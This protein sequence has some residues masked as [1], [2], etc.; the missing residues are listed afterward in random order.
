MQ[1]K[2]RLDE[3]GKVALTAH[4]TS[5]PSVTASGKAWCSPV[6]TLLA[7]DKARRRVRAARGLDGKPLSAHNFRKLLS[8]NGIQTLDKHETGD[9]GGKA[10]TESGDLD[11]YGHEHGVRLARD[12][13]TQLARVVERVMELVQAG[14]KRFRIVTDHGWLLM[15]GGLPKSELPKHQAET[16]WGRCAVHQGHRSRDAADLRWD[17]CQDVQVAYAPGVSCFIAGNEYAH[18]GLSL[19]ECLVPV[20]TLDAGDASAEISVTIASVTWKGLRCVVEVSPDAPGLAVDIRSKPA[21]ASSSLAAS[22]KHVEG[23]KAN[24]AI[25]DDE[26]IG[27][28]AFVVVLNAKG[29]VVQKLATAV[30][31]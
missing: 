26:H 31:G 17:W 10:W 22:V 14:W 21:L 28:A 20:I 9:P 13:D 3:L 12:L 8:D 25:S 27:S 5:M 24:L 15:P 4:W 30:G 19:Q 16:R 11:H 23:G 29:E 7:G 1:L 18:G 6:A 2:E